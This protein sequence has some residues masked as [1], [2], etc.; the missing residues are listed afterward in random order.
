MT[1]DLI[2][3]KDINVGNRQTDRRQKDQTTQ[4][5]RR[6]KDRPRDGQI[7]RQTDRQTERPANR[8]TDRQK[9]GQQMDR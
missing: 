3:T 5:D 8:W 9:T 1:S 4:T 7:G 6:Q 2:S